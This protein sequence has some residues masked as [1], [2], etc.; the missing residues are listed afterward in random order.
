MKLPLTPVRCLLRA[1][2][3]YGSKVGIV[4]GDKRL[5]YAEVLERSLRLASALRSLEVESG[6]RVASLSFNCHQLIELYYGVPMA[7]AVLLSLNVRLSAE[8]QAYILEH[9]GSKLVVFDPELLPLAEQLRKTL[10]QIRWIPLSD[11]P[12][13]PA[14]LDQ[15]SYESL[16]AAADPAPVDYAGYDE[17][18]IAELF[19]TSGSTGRPK[20]VMLSH[21]TLYLHA[22]NVIM[23]YGRLERCVAWDKRVEAHTIPLFHANGWGRPHTITYLGGRHVMVKRFDPQQVCELI[24]REGVTAFS[25]V[26]TMAAAMVHCPDVDRYDLSTLEEITLG[27]AA[28]SPAIVRAVEQKFGCRAFVGYGLTESGPVATTAHPKSTF[29]HLDDEA[30]IRRQSMTGYALPG[31]ELRVVDLEGADVPQD[32][33][34]IGEVLL[35]GDGV[36]DGYWNEPE[37]AAE[38]MEGTWLHT[39]DMAVWDEDRYLLIVDRKK[40]IIISGGENISSIE[41]EKVIAAHPAVYECAVIGVPHEKWGESPKAIVALKPGASATEDEIRNHVRAHLAG[42]KVPGSVE[43]CAELP[44]GATGKILKRVLR[45]PYWEGR[46]V[47]VQGTNIEG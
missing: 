40:D 32:G 21:R 13:A 12:D 28:S 46:E 37:A 2:Q 33:K 35:R 18:A 47:R 34:S 45:E 6:D 43:F 8:E 29:G 44:K 23:G 25:M 16:L 11:L 14:W 30:R 19:Y 10:P 38:A 42:F 4:D 20:G 39:G 41:I 17:D 7:R 24:E 26:P 5:T 31:A 36:M 15:P 27:G 1:G 9:S 22:V 3:E